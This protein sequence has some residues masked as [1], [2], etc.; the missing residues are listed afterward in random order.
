MLVTNIKSVI[1]M[2]DLQQRFF[3]IF[4][5]EKWKN[6]LVM[7]RCN[8]SCPKWQRPG[9]LDTIHT[10]RC[11]HLT[12]HA[13]YHTESKRF[14]SSSTKSIRPRRELCPWPQTNRLA[15]PIWIE[16][17]DSNSAGQWCAT[18]IGTNRNYFRL[19]V[20]MNSDSEFTFAFE[21]ITFTENVRQTT[22]WPIAHLLIS[23]SH[24][25]TC[26]FTSRTRR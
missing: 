17:N 13:H 11:K 12:K 20:A 19:G 1:I 8:L 24:F 26:I 15:L 21:T 6:R 7:S 5:L 23:L 4:F 2:S 10:D 25:S 14:E 18:V 16:S 3:F 22:K 9:R